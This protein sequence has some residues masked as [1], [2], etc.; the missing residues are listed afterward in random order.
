MSLTIED[1]KKLSHLAQLALSP[2]EMA[3]Y[4]P[5]L[6]K[7]LHFVEQIDQANTTNI[8]PLAHPLAFAQR[9][10]KDAVTESNDRDKYQALAPEVE[11]G[12]YLVPKV[13]EEKQ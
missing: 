7:I 4:I 6:T 10:R 9:L 13:I 2:D 3:N 11:A 8:E 5:E 12:L 1:I